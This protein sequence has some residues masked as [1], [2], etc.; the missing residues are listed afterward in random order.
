MCTILLRCVRFKLLRYWCQLEKYNW[1]LFSQSVQYV[2]TVSYVCLIPIC[3]DSFKIKNL[4][5]PA[6]QCEIARITWNYYRSQTE[7]RKGNVF[8]PVRDSVHRGRCTP[9]RQIPPGRP[10]PDRALPLGRH[11]PGQASPVPLH[12]TVRILLE[13]ILVKGVFS[14]KIVKPQTIRQKR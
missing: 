13:C 7:L 1:K 4:P 2:N 5:P 11:P 9:P 6:R 8:T 14:L 10:P 12:Q 3:T